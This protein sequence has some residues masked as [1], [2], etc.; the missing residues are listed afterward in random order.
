V[1]ILFTLTF[2]YLANKIFFRRNSPGKTISTE[3][4]YESIQIQFIPL[5]IET[6][7]VSGSHLFFGLFNNLAIFIILVAVYG[8]LNSTFE[9]S[10]SIIRQAVIGCTF[11]LFA[12]GC[13][14]VKIPVAEGVIVDQRNAIVA[15]S[16][17]FGGPFS[18]LLSAVIT[19]CYRIY[20]GGV[21]TL[22][23][24]VGVGLAAISGGI[25][26]TFRDRIDSI[27]KASTSA[28]AATIIILPGFLFIGDL[29]AGW[30]LLKAMALP[31]G[32]AVFLGI[33]LVGLLLAHEERRHTVE[34]EQKKS[35]ERFR[36]LFEN[37]IDVGYRTDG[38]HRVAVISPSSEK[39]LGYLPDEI[40]GQQ[41]SNFY[42]NPSSHDEF[43]TK[44]LR[45]GQVKNFEAEI[46]KK[47][48][49]SVWVSTNAK[50]LTYTEGSFVGI[51][52]IMRDISQL[53]KAE[54][55]KL[56][57]EE[58]LRQSQKMEAIGTLAGG[59]AHDFNNILAAIIGYTE[60]AYYKIPESSPVRQDMQ[61]VLKAGQRAKELVKHI[62]LFSRKS[63][64]K[65]TPVDIH[66]V[67]QEALKLIRATIPS[68]IRIHQ[69]INFQC[70]TII[71]DQ[72]EIQQII[73][74]LC[75]NAAQE[76]E[77]NGGDL[78]VA[79]QGVELSEEGL[80]IDPNLKTG[81][82]VK[83]SVSDTGHGIS[84]DTIDRIFDPYFTTKEIGKGS[85]LGLA[86]VQGIVK[87]HNAMIT[88]ESNTDG[89][90]FNVFFPKVEGKGQQ[91]EE[92]SVPLP[93]GKERI[94]VVDDEGSVVDVIQKRLALLGY[95][96]T[97]TKSS[98]EAL[99]L[100]R[101]QPNA[102]DLVIT[103]QTMP[104]MTGEQ[105]AREL[106]GLRPDLLVILCT[107]YSSKIL[108]ENVKAIGIKGF[109]MKPVDQKELAVIVR[110][111]LDAH[112][113]ETSGHSTQA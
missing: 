25:F 21:G 107:G 105:L 35:E 66:P 9:K 96:V 14:N 72:T 106:I 83:L 93:T 112:Q 77:K 108:A 88:V 58:S 37:L 34:V 49:S 82:Y 90:I 57:L 20:L 38:E 23:G 40:R 70:G 16:G 84:R 85:G 67:V 104:N 46:R 74:N 5:R 48:G 53:K 87:S 43:L 86:I 30:E 45:D 39:T 97:A 75:M 111:V 91:I 63:V 80:Q 22:G 47:D 3:V 19:G 27:L 81:S 31:Y 26:Y 28:L 65:H 69:E 6:V 29:Q 50:L 78:T 113:Q 13:M 42:K 41:L 98:K 101:L 103:D 12:I 110:G 89:T 99:D 36:E 59:I 18:A 71:A 52:G 2:P 15:L 94:L 60:L 44:I 7:M 11:G 10:T 73:I 102:F 109:I 68:T 55:E 32:S 4:F 1:S 64:Q 8:A 33:L 62:L 100:F 95:Q 56:H 79:L 24:I 51:E 76:M 54:E 17:A 92:T 61:E